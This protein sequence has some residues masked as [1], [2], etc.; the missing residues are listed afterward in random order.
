MYK[1]KILREKC[2]G[3]GLCLLYCMEEAMCVSSQ[4]NEIGYFP[5]EIYAEHRCNGC[6]ACYVMCPEGIVEITQ[7]EDERII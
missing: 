4:V 5:A 7:D 6:K 3:C 1:V 2:K